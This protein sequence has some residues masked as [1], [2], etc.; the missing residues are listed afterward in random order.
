MT[1]EDWLSK[2]KN[3][4]ASMQAESEAAWKAKIKA[5][6]AAVQKPPKDDDI[7]SVYDPNDSS[8]PAREMTYGDYKKFAE[9]ETRK[10]VQENSRLRAMSVHENRQHGTEL[11]DKREKDFAA[12]GTVA[13]NP[14]IP[15]AKSAISRGDYDKALELLAS[16]IGIYYS[17]TQADELHMDLVKNPDVTAEERLAG[18]A[19]AIGRIETEQNNALAKLNISAQNRDVAGSI[20]A[21]EEFREAA[22][23]QGQLDQYQKMYSNMRDD[24]AEKAVE[25]ATIERDDAYAASMSELD[26]FL[27]E[28]TEYAK[29]AGEKE[30]ATKDAYIASA[31][32]NVSADFGAY[33]DD[34]TDVLE[35]TAQ[36]AEK[37]DAAYA[38]YAAAKNKRESLEAQIFYANGLKTLAGLS[39]SDR[40]QLIAY[41]RGGDYKE[42]YK[43]LKSSMNKDDFERMVETVAALE[44]SVRSAERDLGN[45]RFANEHPVMGSIASVFT[46]LVGGVS[47]VAGVAARGFDNLGEADGYKAPIDTNSWAFAPTKHATVTRGTVSENI[48]REVGGT[49]G[50]VASFLY[51]TGMS[52]VDSLAA[53]FTGNWG[54]ALLLGTSSA[55]NA[56]LDAK[57]RGASDS[58]AIWTGLFAGAFETLFERVSIGNLN[59]LKET[60]VG[61]IKDILKN[62]GKSALVNASEEALTEAATAISDYLINGDLSVYGERYN[63]YLE[64]Y[65]DEQKAKEAAMWDMLKDIG[66]AGAGGL[67]MGVG[68]SGAVGGIN[69]ARRPMNGEAKIDGAVATSSK[70]GFKKLVAASKQQIRLFVD[71]AFQKNNEYQYIKTADVTPQLVGVLSAEGIDITGFAHFLKDNEIRHVD[72]SHGSKSNDKYKVTG[73]DII[74]ANFVIE[75]YHALYRGYDTKDGNPAIVYEYSDKLRS[76]Y[77]EEVLEEGG[78]VLKQ[79]MLVGRG[80]KPSFLKKM[81]KIAGAA[82]DTGVT[83]QSRSTDQS[84]PGNHV[85]NAEAHADYTNSISQVSENSQEAISAI[86]HMAKTV[87]RVGSDTMRRFYNGDM[88]EIE[89]TEAF[90]R[91]YND[92]QN[93][94]LV[95]FANG[96]D[97]LNPAQRE[98]A[99]NAGLIDAKVDAA[100]NKAAPGTVKVAADVKVSKSFVRRV[101]KLAKALNVSVTIGGK[102]PIENGAQKRGYLTSDGHIQIYGDAVVKLADGRVLKGEQAALMIVLGHE[103]THR[104]QAL[105]KNSYDRFSNY[106]LSKTGNAVEEY[107]RIYDYSRETAE[108]EVVCDFAMQ[109]LFTDK[110]IIREVTRKHNKVAET[111]R[112]WLEKV[113]ERLGI[114]KYSDMSYSEAEFAK[115]IDEAARLWNEAYNASLE[116]VKNGVETKNTADGDVKYSSEKTSSEVI[117]LSKDN[118]LSAMVDGIY[119][120]ERYSIIKNYILNELRDQPVTLSDGKRAVV[121]NRDAQHIAAHKS[122]S[123]E[124]AEISRIKDIVERAKLVAEENSTKDGKFDYFWYYEASVRFGDETFPIYVNVGRA[125]N[126]SSYHIYDLTKKIRDT[127]HRVYGVERPVGNAL[128]NDISTNMVPQDF[129]GVKSDLSQKSTNGTKRSVTGTEDILY[130][131][132]KKQ[133]GTETKNTA[134]SGVKYSESGSDVL[135]NQFESGI[136]EE[137]VNKEENSDARRKETIPDTSNA[138]SAG[139][140][141]EKA[142]EGKGSNRERISRRIETLLRESSVKGRDNGLKRRG[143]GRLEKIE[144]AEAFEDRVRGEGYMYA[145]FS[146]TSI[147]FKSAPKNE[148]NENAKAAAEKLEELGINVIV[149]KEKILENH[150]GVSEELYLGSTLGVED[151]LTVFISSKLDA[152]GMETAYHEAFHALLRMKKGAKYH[153]KLIDVISDGVDS[154]SESFDKFVSEIAELYAYEVKTVSFERF[155]KEV[156]EEFYAWYIGKIYAN[157]HRH[158]MDMLSYIKQFSDVDNIKAQTDAIFEEIKNDGIRYSTSGTEDILYDNLKKQY[159]TIKPGE[160]PVRDVEV[161]RKTAEG[162][163]VSQTVRTAMEAGATPENMLPTLEK[164]IADEE[165]SYASI[166]D[167]DAIDEAESTIID[168]GFSTALG[169]WY[170]SV[171]K[172]EVSKKNTALGWAL[173]NNAANAG[174]TKTAVDILTAMVEHQRSAAQALQATRILK[175]LSPAGRLY[176]A[177]RSVQNLQRELQEKYGDKA[178]DL[179][180]DEVLADRAING[181]T[182]AEREKALADLYRDVGR[183]MPSSVMDKWNAWR[184]L[185]MLGN[186]RTHVR[187]IVGNAGFAP[188]VAVKNI[189]AAGIE[190]AVSFVTKGKIGRTKAFLTASEADKALLAAAWSDYGTVV[191]EALGQTKYNDK[192]YAN[193]YIEEGRRIFKFKPL[194]A[195][196]RGNA[197]LL[198]VEDSW[199]AKPHY[200]NALAQ[201]CKA[202]GITAEQVKSGKGLENA[203]LYAIKEAQKATYRDTNAVSE[204]FSKLGRISETGKFKRTKKIWNGLVEGVLPFRKTPANILARGIEYSP[205]GI[206]GGVV[207]LF[208]IK[209]GKATAAEAIDRFAAGLTGTGLLALGA[210]L[211]SQGVLRGI[212]GDDEKEKEFEELMGHQA[213]ALEIG[214]TSVTLDWLAPEALPFFVGANIAEQAMQD[215]EM[216]IE[217]LLSALGSISDPMLSMSCLQGLNDLI[218]SVSYSKASGIATIAASA[219]TSYLTQGIPTLSGQIERT[220]ERERMTTYISGKSGIASNMRY[221]LGKTSAKIPGVDYSQI[222]YIDAW[223]RTE[224]S[225]NVGVRAANNMLN[226]AYTSTIN[227]SDM[228]KELLRLYEQTGEP[229]FP[230]RADKSFPIG[231]EQVYLTAEQYQKYATSKGQT[232]YEL[233]T[234]ITGAKAYAGMD[235]YQKAEAISY[236]YAYANAIAKRDVTKDFETPYAVASWVAKAEVGVA[237]GVSVAEFILAKAAISEIDGGYT[238]IKTG[239]TIDN[240]KSL[241]IMEAIYNIPGL[242]EKKR[243]YLFEALGVGTKVRHYN[244]ACVVE[245]LA[246]MRKQAGM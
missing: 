211:V 16:G 29:E 133:Y 173:Y 179:R 172:G 185:S 226:P 195:A 79:V 232:S 158:S 109:Y 9:E 193:R 21:A 238:N 129:N 161:P 12:S 99:Y 147:A 83:A 77:V 181:E 91:Y 93:N 242:S 74:N 169:D 137:K 182:E 63:A 70:N 236:A 212:G 143:T 151:Y 205:I 6:A 13:D 116:N 174:D 55:S 57:E 139:R 69:Y 24:P 230:S 124:A 33:G 37:T 58:Q 223:G 120:S 153:H 233:A 51:Q 196:R 202:N 162:K 71:N 66:I 107:M 231:G 184:Y 111:F 47:A 72:I 60:P 62:I 112:A 90:L 225:G 128:L 23:K 73:D 20:N 67:V 149:F 31:N 220:F 98:A 119:G 86:E 215:G 76:F 217:G 155:S 131:N 125:K 118:K 65:G 190:T 192:Q 103:L 200:A 49:G 199:F 48:E 17:Q 80:R 117:D 243:K 224:A 84:P 96:T 121:D 197:K 213:Y 102:A 246:K 163:N 45:V 227:E 28:Y 168:N 140:M 180:I 30:K 207:D 167:N 203:R 104:L 115:I 92:G 208:K 14:L 78:L 87:G 127:A 177:Q 81:K 2:I 144:T 239:E 56:F 166:A 235:D 130:E 160:K 61:T 136:L 152:D 110:K 159:D 237:N 222:P 59:A 94:R 32:E 157:K 89:Y 135:H 35:Q 122:S 132:M 53:S 36:F 44:N 97:A 228:E 138:E 26:A 175:K 27:A 204:L 123:K 241:L 165:F 201:F 218:E 154:E 100:K 18:L 105:D 42:T 145:T 88:S 187:N 114:D 85:Q 41:I 244:K 194:E 245:Q 150:N 5:D 75:N 43:R 106:V 214:N 64:Q 68:M 142:A 186:A 156:A 1:K 15:T 4:S 3:D 210:F 19:K 198:D 146:K 170:V 40:I 191:D 219:A 141:G 34:T 171:G 113:Y 38:E 22:R 7:V 134:D 95:D 52:G 164:L 50:K 25:N 188:V 126:D 101:E 11:A 183:Q 54:G 8:A 206:V 10:A 108:E 221:T 39:E 189:T 178:P 176:A 240:S 234:A 229:V 209:N 46:S 148:W 216:T 82:S